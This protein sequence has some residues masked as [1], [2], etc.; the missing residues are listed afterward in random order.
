MTGGAIGSILAQ[1]LHLTADERKTLLVAGAASGMAATFNSPLAAVLLAV[2]LLLFEWRPR[3]FVPVAAGVAVATVVRGVIL[4]TAPIFPVSTTGL[5]LTPGIEA[6]AAVV[7]ISGA[8]VAAGATWL[9]YRAE[10]AFSRLPIH[11]MWWPA[12]GGLI[13]GAGGSSNPAPSASATT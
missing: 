4:G 2:E 1:H 3:S 9:V 5:H 8:I 6:L 11:W 12:I 7:G 13:I 10:D